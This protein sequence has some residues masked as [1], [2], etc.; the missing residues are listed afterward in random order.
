MTDPKTDN[1]AQSVVN[2]SK[3]Q[4]NDKEVSTKINLDG[5]KYF[6]SDYNIDEYGELIDNQN[7]QNTRFY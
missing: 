1:N 5:T 4:K 6:N 2:D 7:W 3:N